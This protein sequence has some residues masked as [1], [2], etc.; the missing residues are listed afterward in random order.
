MTAKNVKDS[1]YGLDRAGAF[2]DGVMAIAITLLIL[3]VRV[4]E[5][6]PRLIDADLVRQVL[7]L[8]PKYLGYFTSFWV[9]GLYWLAH[10]RIFGYIRG[11]DRRLLI[12]NLLFLFFVAFMPFPTALLF[13]YPAK[14][15]TVAFY[16][17]TLAL[18]GLTLLWL[19]LYALRHRGFVDETLAPSTIR[20]TTRGLLAT[21]LIFLTSV[22]IAL[23]NPNW[24]MLSWLLFIP[25]YVVIR[26]AEPD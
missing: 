2:S 9:I 4:P 8:W 15:I 16:A 25:V 23:F 14:L 12:L 5:I 7:A 3:E 24:A 21:A 6:E 18:M 19:W 11:Y 1:S 17:G 10:H 13:S 22:A 20:S 26:P